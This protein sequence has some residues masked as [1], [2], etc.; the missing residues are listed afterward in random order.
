[1]TYH[2][3]NLNIPNA[4]TVLRMILIIPF[5]IFY[6]NKQYIPAVVTLIISGITDALDGFVAR[7]FNQFTELGKML[8]PLSDKLTQGSVALCLAIQCPILLPFFLIFIIK[9]VGMVIAA[10]VLIKKRKKPCGSKWYGKIATVL[11]YISFVTIVAMRIWDIDNMTLTVVLLS[12]TA[13]FM[14]YALVRYFVI[15]LSILRSDDPENHLD[16][17]EVMDKQITSDR[18]D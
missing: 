14:I 5:V 1:M 8:D 10:L 16:I 13:F 4:L 17:N 12:I 3:K 11:F 18:K 9:E 7:H 15:F 2:N 6:V